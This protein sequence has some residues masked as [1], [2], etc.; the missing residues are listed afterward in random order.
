MILIYCE[1]ILQIHIGSVKWKSTCTGLYQVMGHDSSLGDRRQDLLHCCY[2]GD[3]EFQE[4][5][6]ESSCAT[7]ILFDAQ[8]VAELHAWVEQTPS[9]GLHQYAAS[10]LEHL[11]VT[12]VCGCSW[13]FGS[14]DCAL[15]CDGLGGSI[16]G[17]HKKLLLNVY[18]LN[19][20]ALLSM[21]RSDTE[22]VGASEKSRCL[23]TLHDGW[24]VC[25]YPRSTRIMG[26]SS[27]SC[28]SAC[29]C[30]VMWRLVGSR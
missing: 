12:G 29:E 8:L 24:S 9:T 14:Y 21:C 6:E 11:P 3:E 16:L 18:L 20:S 1:R 17:E 10:E 19:E 7:T 30:S 22:S 27:C 25:R 13:S 28:T 4:G 15:R 2:H 26:P 5:G 23:A